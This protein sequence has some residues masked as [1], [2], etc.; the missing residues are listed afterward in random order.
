MALPQLQGFGQEFA[1][2][3][4]GKENEFVYM[5]LRNL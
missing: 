2:T 3:A 4:V 1:T 5:S